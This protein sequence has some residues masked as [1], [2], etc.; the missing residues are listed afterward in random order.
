MGEID[1]RWAE[2]FN[3]FEI[4]IER[5]DK[6]F[7]LTT[8]ICPAIDQAKLRGMLNKLWDLNLYLLSVRQVRDPTSEKGG[9]MGVPIETDGAHPLIGEQ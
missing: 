5:S 7:S 6:G 9:A 1:D 4:T 2:W 3:G 8:M